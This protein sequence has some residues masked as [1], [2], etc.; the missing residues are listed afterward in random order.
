M[1]LKIRMCKNRRIGGGGGAVLP[2]G[3][4]VPQCSECCHPTLLCLSC[5]GTVTHHAEKDDSSE[6]WTL[7]SF[8]GSNNTVEVL[9]SLTFILKTGKR[10][11][12]LLSATISLCS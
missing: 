12:F 4:Q 8:Q 5:T 1:R 2:A 11:T 7:S 10:C 6:S 3:S 9:R